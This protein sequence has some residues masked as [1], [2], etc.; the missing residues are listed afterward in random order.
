MERTTSQAT[1]KSGA[2]ARAGKGEEEE[3]GEEAGAGAGG[4]QLGLWA[5]S[6]IHDRERK[7]VLPFSVPHLIAEDGNSFY[8]FFGVESGGNPNTM[9]QHM[10]LIHGT[11]QA[12]AEFE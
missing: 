8:H 7:I 9:T 3:A 5:G 10:P 11:W 12:Q 1:R 4:W 2:G 6:R